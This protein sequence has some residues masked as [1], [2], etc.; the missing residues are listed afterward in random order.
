MIMPVSDNKAVTIV[1]IYNEHGGDF[2]SLFTAALLNY[3]KSNQT[4]TPTQKQIVVKHK[5]ED[6]HVW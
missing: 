3:L 6:T 4:A 5:E 2:K 1:N